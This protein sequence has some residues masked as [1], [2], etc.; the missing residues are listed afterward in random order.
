MLCCTGVT[1]QAIRLELAQEESLRAVGDSAPPRGSDIGAVECVIAGLD[2]EEKR[3]ELLILNKTFSHVYCVSRQLQE[4][5]YLKKTV[6]TDKQVADIVDKR[7][8][9]TRL[10]ARYEAL[11]THF[12]PIAAHVRAT[13]PPQS[14]KDVHGNIVP[15]PIEDVHIILPYTLTIEKRAPGPGADIGEIER[16]ATRP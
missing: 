13:T 7:T 2:L 10:H 15:V 9:H 12:M 6:S 1:L 5:N 16:S 14:M 11:Q 4:A 8:R 3:Y